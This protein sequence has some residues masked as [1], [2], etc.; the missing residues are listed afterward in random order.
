MEEKKNYI[1]LV[2]SIEEISIWAELSSTVRIQGGSPERDGAE[3][4]YT[5]NTK[6]PKNPKK[7]KKKI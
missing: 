6:I 5:K 2:L 3:E 4:G 7:K 1:S